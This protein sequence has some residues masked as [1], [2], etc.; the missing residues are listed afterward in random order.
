MSLAIAVYLCHPTRPGYLVPASQVMG[1]RTLFP[2]GGRS[3]DHTDRPLETGLPTRGG[4]NDLHIAIMDSG[5]FV[6]G[7]M[8]HYLAGIYDE[9]IPIYCEGSIVRLAPLPAPDAWTCLVHRRMDFGEL[10]AKIWR[11][12]LI[13]I[14]DRSIQ[15]C[16]LIAYLTR[17]RFELSFLQAQ[18]LRSVCHAFGYNLVVTK[19][20]DK[21][22]SGD[23][24]KGIFKLSRRRR[25]KARFV[26]V[27]SAYR[28]YVV[29]DVLMQNATGTYAV[30]GLFHQPPRE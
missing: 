1:K 19:I 27:L 30:A 2:V 12:D 5:D 11:G 8:G 28:R 23:G 17:K 18:L 21:K 13:S 6:V 24:R 15:K 29:F 3:R 9:A 4:T 25:K 7:T 22:V 10:L 16:L 14:G 20:G 26:E